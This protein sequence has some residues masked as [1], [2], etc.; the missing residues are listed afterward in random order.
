MANALAD[1][2]AY[3]PGTEGLLTFRG[4]PHFSLPDVVVD[5][6]AFHFD[7]NGRRLVRASLRLGASRVVGLI[8]PFHNANLPSLQWLQRNLNNF[9]PD[10]VFMIIGDCPARYQ[11]PNPRLFYVGR[12]ATFASHLSACD[13]VLIPRFFFIGTPMNKMIYSMAVGLPVV[14]NAAEGMNLVNGQNAILGKLEDLPNLTNVLLSDPQ[15][16]QAIGKKGR[17][18]I[19]ESYSLKANA[20]RFGACVKAVA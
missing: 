14:T 7:E 19:V 20:S 5:T 6:D 18:L 10:V 11:V 13:C 16:S 15:L 17:D 2:I 8:G 3:P 12:V 9:D 4:K 1:A